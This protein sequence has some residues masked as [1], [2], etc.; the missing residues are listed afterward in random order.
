MTSVTYLS[1]RQTLTIQRDWSIW[2]NYLLLDLMSTNIL[3]NCPK[4]TQKICH[5]GITNLRDKNPSSKDTHRQN[6]EHHLRN[7]ERVPPV[8]IRDIA[9]VLLNAEQPS[10][11]HAV[12]YVEP[13][14]KV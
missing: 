14:H 2:N 6:S 8:M 9:V 12:V 7:I 3:R 1:D 13:L 5:S 10:A 11:Q 4:A